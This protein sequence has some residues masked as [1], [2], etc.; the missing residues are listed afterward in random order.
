LQVVENH[1]KGGNFWLVTIA[2]YEFFRLRRYR[3]V[4]MGKKIS[5]RNI[6]DGF[7]LGQEKALGNFLKKWYADAVIMNPEAHDKTML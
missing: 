5:M 2:G 6:R 1:P 3:G 4:V 7:K